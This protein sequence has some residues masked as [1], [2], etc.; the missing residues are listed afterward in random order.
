MSGLRQVLTVC[1]LTVLLVPT[2]ASAQAPR[3]ISLKAS[4]NMKYDVTQISAKP[5]ESLRVRLTATGTVPKIAMAH[6]F[7]LLAA[8]ADPNAF[9]MAAASART[10]DYIP[11]QLKRSVLA[12]TILAGPGETVDVTF[13]A[14]TK[15]GKYVFLCSFPGHYNSGMTGI[16]TVK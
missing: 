7:V 9:V 4:D 13:K 6:N 1:A 2:M 11:A 16:L 10:T 5:G 12:S 15:P 8:D 14:P 3:V